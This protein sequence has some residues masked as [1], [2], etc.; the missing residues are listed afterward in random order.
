MYIFRPIACI[1]VLTVTALA[2]TVDV[3]DTV[4]FPVSKIR[5]SA[6]SVS[7]CILF[8]LYYN[9]PVSLFCPHS[10]Y[11]SSPSALWL[12]AVRRRWRG[13]AGMNWEQARAPGRHGMRKE[14]VNG[15]R[16][17]R[18]FGICKMNEIPSP[19]QHHHH[20]S[21]PHFLSHVCVTRLVKSLSLKLPRS[22]GHQ[23]EK[24][25]NMRKSKR[26]RKG[27]G[28]W[29]KLGRGWLQIVCLMAATQEAISGDLLSVMRAPELPGS[30]F[31]L[32]FSVGHHCLRASGYHRWPRLLKLLCLQ[33]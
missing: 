2:S 30:L 15:P 16:R 33:F 17:Q 6:T 29:E 32:L 20:L 14:Y 8:L 25:S 18:L 26:E 10:L 13:P 19:S 4:G 23:S 27:G 7:F 9:V 3:E 22:M 24:L 11:C 1:N 5:C 21:F 28:R 12:C 31:S